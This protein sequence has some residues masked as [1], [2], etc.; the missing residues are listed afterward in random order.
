M[1]HVATASRAPP[2]PRVA[3]LVAASNRRCPPEVSASW[4]ARSHDPNALNRSNVDAGGGSSA[5]SATV[6]SECSSVST[7]MSPV[8]PFDA[9]AARWSL[10]DCWASDPA[11]RAAAIDRQLAVIGNYTFIQVPE[12]LNGTRVAELLAM[13]ALL[14]GVPKSESLHAITARAYAGNLTGSDLDQDVVMS[15]AVNQTH[16]VKRTGRYDVAR[17][18]EKHADVLG[19]QATRE[20]DPVT[21]SNNCA[22]TWW[23]VDADRTMSFIRHFSLTTD[24]SVPDTVLQDTLAFTSIDVT[25]PAPSA[26]PPPAPTGHWTSA[27]S[28]RPIPSS[29][30]HRSGST[31]PVVT[32]GSRGPVTVVLGPITAIYR[33][34]MLPAGLHRAEEAAL[35]KRLGL[36]DAE[37]RAADEAAEASSPS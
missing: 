34:I 15:I 6:M 2:L 24:A 22:P 18:L 14:S 16:L 35:M 29:S 21:S 31:R 13:Q 23:P 32:S 36:A 11:D 28:S 30:F 33:S 3:T 27:S 25:P 9:V 20:S 5:R 19:W 4:S 1:S 26:L 17:L 12:P 10:E 7:A 37:R 8:G